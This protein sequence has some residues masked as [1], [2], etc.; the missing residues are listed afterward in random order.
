MEVSYFGPGKHLAHPIK[1]KTGRERLIVILKYTFRVDALGRVEIDEESGADPHTADVHDG[2]PATTSIRK[3][4][5]VVDE[6]PGTDV[7]LVGHAHAPR[8]RNASSVDV[9]LRVGAI[10]KTLRVHGLRVWQW[11]TFGGLSPGPARP[12]V[13]PVPLVWELAWGGLDVSDPAGPAGEPR[14]TLGRGVARDP[15]K[16]VGQPGA[17]IEYPDKP[18]GKGSNVPAGFGALCRHWEPRAA[19]AGTYDER[20]EENKMPLPPDDFDPR[21][22]VTAPPDQW[23]SAPLRGDEP[24]EVRGAT[25][26][27]I[28]RFQ[29]PRLAPGFSAVIFGKRTEHRTHLDTVL[30]DADAM[31]VELTYRAAIPMPRKYDMIE[32][33]MVF[34]KDV[35][36]RSSSGDPDE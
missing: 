3:P 21:F 17:Q 30:I 7:L 31:A 2:D 16:L 13:E 18:I 27:G 26:E 19:F 5:D 28:W 14:N 12:I 4:S 15:K 35:L 11:G 8:G 34:E 24:I 22:N 9:S 20:W 10:Q 32:S 6:K 29:L 25:P 1:D 23:C 33:V 36:S